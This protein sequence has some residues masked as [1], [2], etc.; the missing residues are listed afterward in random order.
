MEDLY[1]SHYT[2]IS[3]WFTLFKG[4]SLVSRRSLW[5]KYAV[6]TRSIFILN[7]ITNT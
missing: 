4:I 6:P 5:L 1:G 7:G 2:K 3:L